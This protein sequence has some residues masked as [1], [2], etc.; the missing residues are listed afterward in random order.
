MRSLPLW[1]LVGA[2]LGGGVV[3]WVLGGGSQFRSS[4]PQEAS[5]RTT[6]PLERTQTPAVPSAELSNSG[7]RTPSL[8]EAPPLRGS[9]TLTGRAADSVGKPLFG[10]VIRASA[11][12]PSLTTR[13]ASTA[14]P[15]RL[16]LEDD[17]ALAVAAVK[18]RRSQEFET[19]TDGDG[20][21]SIENMPPGRYRVRAYL[22]GYRMSVGAPSAGVPVPANLEIEGIPVQVL[23]VELVSADGKAPEAAMLELKEQ[24]SES[25]FKTHTWAWTR[26]SPTIEC[27]DG[28]WSARAQFSGNEA[29]TCTATTQFPVGQGS[30]RTI[31]IEVAP[32]FGIYGRLLYPPGELASHHSVLV[33]NANEPAPASSEDWGQAIMAKSTGDSF[34]IRDLKPGRWRVATRGS[35]GVVDNISEVDVAS[36]FVEKNIEIAATPRSGCVVVTVLD[37]EG[38]PVPRPQLK[39]ILLSPQQSSTTTVSPIKIGQ[40]GIWIPLPS[41]V[42]AM[43]KGSSQG[44]VKYSIQASS[45]L[46]AAVSA[47]VPLGEHMEATLRFT[48]AATVEVHLEAPIPE[49]IAR[50]LRVQVVEHVE[51]SG[52]FHNNAIH[53]GPTPPISR[54]GPFPPGRARVILTLASRGSMASPLS[55]AIIDIAP[56]DNVYKLKVPELHTVTVVGGNAGERV[57]VY[58]AA[59]DMHRFHE[60]ASKFNADGE[61]RFPLL[62]EGLHQI[63]A[64][65]VGKA[66]FHV[67]TRL[68]VDLRT[69][70]RLS[71]MV[72]IRNPDDQIGSEVKAGDFVIAIDGKELNLPT[73]DQDPRSP[74]LTA[75]TKSLTLL[76]G[77][78]RTEVPLTEAM[79]EKIHEARWQ[80][81][82]V[83]TF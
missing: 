32:A 79:R 55:T 42:L 49:A 73:S 19:V 62:T 5:N 3:Y 17:V 51:G 57:S 52:I 40:D 67:P 59:D 8:A 33:M 35:G 46:Y 39:S 80:L 54:H 48:L 15:P 7:L 72:T 28:T 63:E 68:Q 56:G 6:A 45:P 25:S 24:T 4:P 53:D 31:K 1:F 21:F 20:N 10:A 75:T 66:Y 65:G 76:R 77:T 50:E 44:R 29:W 60:P 78:T 61:A 64:P 11:V 36:G 69:Q 13:M 16:S 18:L 58:S 83:R 38:K 9:A 14:L 37:P 27:V 2:A 12:E 81:E 23:T 70:P 41:E 30:P 22:A 43:R 71:I 74:L 82:Y 26:A 34:E 47:E